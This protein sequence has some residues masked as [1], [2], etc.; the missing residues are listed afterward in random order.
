MIK[1]LSLDHRLWD[2]WKV[3]TGYSSFLNK[4]HVPLTWL[5]CYPLLGCP[6]GP[7]Q[8]LE[9]ASSVQQKIQNGREIRFPVPPSPSPALLLNLW[10]LRKKR[11]SPTFP[12]KYRGSLQIKIML[13]EQNN[14]VWAPNSKLLLSLMIRARKLSELNPI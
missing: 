3:Q 13:G 10:F 11:K 14:T 1:M 12:G 9:A 5:I 6:S 2:L 8:K 7:T 4:N